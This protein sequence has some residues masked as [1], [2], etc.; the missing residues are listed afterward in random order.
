MLVGYFVDMLKWNFMV[1]M[2]MCEEDD[3]SLLL[4]LRTMQCLLESPTFDDDW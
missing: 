1:F 2:V 3:E 4:Q